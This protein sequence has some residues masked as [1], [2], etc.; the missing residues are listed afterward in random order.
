[1]TGVVCAVI[2]ALSTIICAV[3]AKQG[4]NRDKR[5]KEEQ[6]R[7]EKREKQRLKEAMLQLAMISANTKLTLGVAMALK[8]GHCNGEVEEG[9][10][11]VAEASK[12]YEQYLEEIA[13]NHLRK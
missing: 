6:E 3:I 8:H 5:E 4:S 2:T 1:M 7:N 12:E 9:M 13:M 11:A 10:K